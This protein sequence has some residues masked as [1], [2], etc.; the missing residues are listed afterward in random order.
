MAAVSTPTQ[1]P[2]NFN[3]NPGQL[4]AAAEDRKRA[5]I[6]VVE[7]IISEVHAADATFE[8]SILP[9]IQNENLRSRNDPPVGFLEEVSPSK[10]LRDASRQ[11][12]V[13]LSDS[14]QDVSTRE[15]IYT[16]VTAV[17]QKENDQ[18]SEDS[19]QYLCKQRRSLIENGFSIPKGPQRDRYQEV[20][21]RITTLRSDINKMGNENKEGLWLTR[22]QLDGV[23][24]SLIGTLPVGDPEGE[25]FGKLW[26]QLWCSAA[27]TVKSSS[28]SSSTRRL[29][30]VK[31][32]YRCSESAEP[33]RELLILR[34]EAARLLGYSSYAAF[35]LETYLISTPAILEN[36]FSAFQSQTLSMVRR[37][38]EELLKVKKAY[39]NEHPQDAW[40]T[41]DKLFL[42]DLSFYRKMIQSKSRGGDLQD[43]REY[44]P[45]E[46]TFSRVLELLEQLFCIRFESITTEEDKKHVASPSGLESL[47]WH[48][49]VMMFRVWDTKNSASAF[50]GYLYYDVYKREGKANKTICYSL[51]KVC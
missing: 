18:L 5:A 39:L 21:K 13:L 35:Q 23:P 30:T 26:L 14:M 27:I 49:D 45:F 47:T 36:F 1:P 2:M 25:N 8:N 37:T 51:Q 40:D 12:Q 48:E 42:W 19:K 17:L 31:E 3:P 4:L 20:R 7:K 33:M 24:E 10:D 9:L 41:P 6:R 28:S 46:T 32:S 44:F 29:V 38:H 11:A 16:I 50:L 43:V 15:E 34:D 22:E